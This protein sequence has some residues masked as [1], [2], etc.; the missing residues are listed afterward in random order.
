[1]IATWLTWN[2]KVWYVTIFISHE[3]LGTGLNKIDY[4]KEISNWINLFNSISCNK[5]IPVIET[6]NLQNLFIFSGIIF[7]WIIMPLF[8]SW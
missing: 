3:H 1:M 2:W 6:Y 4:I 8:L 5:F 7:H